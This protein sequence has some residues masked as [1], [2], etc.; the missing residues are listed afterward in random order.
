MPDPASVSVV[1]PMR[2]VARAARGAAA[3]VLRA[4][5]PWRSRPT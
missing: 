2:D 4:A 1:I 3:A 5:I